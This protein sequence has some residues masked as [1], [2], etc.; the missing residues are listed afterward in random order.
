MME[1]GGQ[2]EEVRICSISEHTEL[3]QGRELNDGLKGPYQ[4]S[5]KEGQNFFFRFRN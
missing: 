1:G 5:L 2:E 3:V 4:N